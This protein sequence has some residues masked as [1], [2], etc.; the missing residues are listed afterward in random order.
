MNWRTKLALN[1]MRAAVN[2]AVDQIQGQEFTCDACDGRLFLVRG[3]HSGKWFYS[4]EG[5]T[6]C[7]VRPILFESREQAEQATEVFK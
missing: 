5:I 7:H 1:E 2:A 6:E 3:R 4:H